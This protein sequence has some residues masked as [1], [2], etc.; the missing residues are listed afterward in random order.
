M[1]QKWVKKILGGV[2][3]S[4]NSAAIFLLLILTLL[5]VQLF[6]ETESKNAPSIELGKISLAGW[7][8]QDR[9]LVLAGNWEFYWSQYLA[10]DNEPPSDKPVYGQVPGLWHKMT[11]IDGARVAESWGYATYRLVV[12]DIPPG[13]YALAIPI[14]YAPSRVWVNGELKSSN[15]VLGKSSAEEV[16]VWKGHDFGFDTPTDMVEI[17]VEVSDHIHGRG[18]FIEPPIL[19][20]ASVVSDYQL[21]F[22]MRDL[23]VQGIATILFVLGLALFMFRRQDIPSLH[24][25]MFSLL[26][27]TMLSYIGVN[28]SEVVIPSVDFWIKLN[29]YYVAE[30]GSLGFI[31]AYIA[32]LYPAERIKRL[33]QLVY[34]ICGVT[35]LVTTV[36]LGFKPAPIVVPLL[37]LFINF[38]IPAVCVYALVTVIRA[39]RHDREGAWIFLF[40]IAVLIW[41]AI[42]EM[43]VTRAM[44]PE[45]P[46]LA[47]GKG[48]TSLG[49]L[50]FLLSQIII[51]AKRWTYTL[52]ASENMTQD[53]SRLIDVTSAIS[54]EVKLDALLQRIVHGA[55]EFIRAERSTLF[56]YDQK[57]QELWSLVAEGIANKEIRFPANVGL[58]GTSFQTGDTINV[59]D[60]YQDDRFNKAFDI[61]NNFHTRNILT[62]PV[63]T[64]NGKRIGVMQ[65][66]NKIGGGF[67]VRDE[68]R[69]RAF[70]AQTAIAIENAELF[71]EITQAKNYNESI[72][73]SMSNGV[74]TINIDGEIEKINEAALTILEGEKTVLMNQ[75]VDR[76]LSGDNA[77]LAKELVAVR[78]EATPRT[79]LDVDVANF[80]TTVKSLNLSVIPLIG[81]EGEDIGILMLLEDITGAKRLRGTMSRFMTKEI[82]DRIL[83]DGEDSLAGSMVNASI[84]FADM[85]GFTGIT[86]R[87]SPQQTVAMLN[88]FFGDMTEAVFNWNGVLDK[89]MGDSMMALFGAPLESDA[90]ADNSLASAVEMMQILRILNRRR[91]KRGEPA[92]NISIGI[93]TGDVVAGT[94]GSAKRMEYTVVGDSVNL[95]SRLE[96]ITRF[97]GAAIVVSEETMAAAKV[98]ILNRELDLIRVKGRETPATIYEILEHH[99]EQTF[100]NMS[101]VID[102]YTEGLAAYRNRSWDA[103]IEAFKAALAGNP[104]DQASRIYLERAAVF[105]ENPPLADWDGVWTMTSK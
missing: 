14:L 62:M 31:V 79:F 59:V 6:I 104:D 43:F 29:I 24:F 98:P 17:L 100:Q 85:R 22:T 10:T 77:W 81:E 95:A 53:L 73:G 55:T 30:V 41:C 7:E 88:E 57:S 74:V 12:N 93:A 65:V 78:Q 44:I 92:I 67:E 64:K 9:P 60:A 27:G 45:M 51:L 102:R 68:E 94:I 72:L 76:W 87:L 5:G 1:A 56:L 89:F 19:G 28:I 33:D 66:L 91:E 23:L 103:A 83:E 63:E 101:D 86:E 42:G 40:G 69:L 75:P 35:L 84:L 15:G 20:P 49:F 52:K 11:N 80:K 34:A 39:C 36:Q 96:G 13:N 2:F 70:T 58:A 32:A 99:T 3:S 90:D 18:R 26:F 4:A 25:S 37:S 16:A 8:F 21:L 46:L 47:I 61:K 48:M 82:A 71:G 54:S 38:V 97:Y 105:K 50:I